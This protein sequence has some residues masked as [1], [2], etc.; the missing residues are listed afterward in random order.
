MIEPLLD[1][2][3]LWDWRKWCGLMLLFDLLGVQQSQD[4]IYGG[5]TVFFTKFPPCFAALLLLPVEK[6][7]YGVSNG[8]FWKEV[9]N[10][11]CPFTIP[12][13]LAHFLQHYC[14]ISE[15]SHA[16]GVNFNLE[17][18][19]AVRKIHGKKDEWYFL[20]STGSCFKLKFANQIAILHLQ[21]L[22]DSGVFQIWKCAI[23]FKTL[24]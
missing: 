16:C 10:C 23:C 13:P 2:C 6:M 1:T 20:H 22:V 9:K 15:K 17:E 18:S 5:D 24:H 4:G 21:K 19:V 8:S 12:I 11:L 3:G 14:K 7:S